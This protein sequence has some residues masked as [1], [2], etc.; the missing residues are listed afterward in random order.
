MK[1]KKLPE[2]ELEVMLALWEENSAAS[3][4]SIM[5]KLD[6]KWTKPTLLKLLSRLCERG[7]AECEKNGRYNLYR[8]VVKRDDYLMQETGG[9]FK[10][11]HKGSV[12][13][14]VAALYDGKSITKE[15]LDELEEYIR[16][17]K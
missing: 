10:K 16:S 7:F 2:A 14:L 11:L 5:E 15:D 3:S 13:S 12:T 6:K 9:F 4:E 8:A 1:Y 17:A